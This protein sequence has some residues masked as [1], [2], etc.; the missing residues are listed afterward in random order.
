MYGI[1]LIRP[2]SKEN[3]RNLCILD[4]VGIFFLSIYSFIWFFSISAPSNLINDIKWAVPCDFQQ[5]GILTSVDSD[6]PV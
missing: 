5:C 6:E 2:D 3:V 4:V 1:S